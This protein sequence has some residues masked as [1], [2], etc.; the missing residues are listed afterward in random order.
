M[1]WNN[2]RLLAVF[3]ALSFMGL[4]ADGAAH[5]ANAATLYSFCT[6]FQKP[7]CLDGETPESRLLQVGEQLYG[8]TSAGGLAGY[9]RSSTAKAAYGTL[10]RISTSG[11]FKTLYNFCQQTLCADGASPG[12]YLTSGPQNEIYGVAEGGGKMDG[13]T[14]FKITSNGAF[15]VVYRF[16]SKKYCADGFQPVSV[17]FKDGVLYGTTAAGGSKGGGTVF[18]IDASG[19]LKILHNFCGNS[20]CTD[21]ITPG[22]LIL[23]KDGVFYGTAAA[24][25]KYNGGTVFKVTTAGVLT[26]LHSF[27]TEKACADGTVP[28]VKLVQGDDRNFYGVTTGGGA[29]A[30]GTAFQ[31]T[32][33][34]DWKLL[35]SFCNS[36]FCYDGSTPVDGLTLAKDGSFYGVAS[37]GGHFYNGVLFHL[38]TAGEYSVAYQFCATRGCFDGSGPSAAPTL[39]SDGNLYGVTQ[40]GGDKDDVGAIYQMKP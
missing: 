18:T 29:N 16:C 22:A 5:T 30:A 33:A 1:I 9:Q 26:T 24:G 31:I 8:T 11:V 39:G 32:P 17:I 6:D 25:G 35:H 2:A 7:N 19:T 27:C 34:G 10:F 37:A 3:L 15:T 36:N 13:G 40:T 12:S 28:T 20:S 21:G 4:L 23:G 38:T 14:V